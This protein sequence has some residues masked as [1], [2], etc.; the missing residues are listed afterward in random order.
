MGILP[1]LIGVFAL[2]GAIAFFRIKKINQ[3]LLNLEFKIDY[4]TKQIEGKNEKN[5]GKDKDVYISTAPP[6]VETWGP[7]ETAPPPKP[8]TI[9]TPSQPHISLESE[10]PKVIQKPPTDTTLI[11]LAWLKENWAG[12]LGV[13]I[14]VLGITFGTVYLS[15]FASPLLRFLILLGIG[16]GFFGASQ[17]IKTKQFVELSFWLRSASG[18]IVLFTMLASSF[19]EALHFYQSPQV[20]LA[21][22]VAGLIYNMAL[23]YSATKEHFAAFH[24]LICLLALMIVPKELPVLFS[25]LIVCLASIGISARR[26]W[27][28]NLTVSFI[29]YSIFHALWLREQPSISAI[30]PIGI[31]GT[32]LV[33]AGA[34]LVHYLKIYQNTTNQYLI[35]HII[36]WLFLGFDLALYNIGFSYLFIPLGI[37]TVACFS[38]S[39]YAKRN[40]IEW[41]FICD[42]LVGQVLAIITIL[43]LTRL[44]LNDQLIAWIAFV[45][46]VCF[47]TV[48]Y[49]TRQF[50][51]SKVGTGFTLCFFLAFVA[52]LFVKLH[53][54]SQTCLILA[55]ALLPLYIIR[56]LLVKRQ[57]NQC[58][59]FDTYEG[60]YPCIIDGLFFI[61]G[62]LTLVMG[63]DAF[64]WGY[65]L[66]IAVLI[67]MTLNKKLMANNYHRVFYL[68]FCVLGVVYSW[69]KVPMIEATSTALIYYGLPP[70]A[71]LLWLFK[72]KLFYIDE[73]RNIEDLWV[74]LVGFHIAIIGTMLSYAYSPFLP[75]ALYLLFGLI[76]FETGMVLYAGSQTIRA[77]FLSIACKNM[78]LLFLI[79]YVLIY[80]LLYIQS[81]ASLFTYLSFAHA[82]TIIA[83]ALSIYWYFSRPI[84]SDAYPELQGRLSVKMLAV[85][86]SVTFDIAFLLLICLLI[87]TFSAPLHPIGYGILGLLLSVPYLRKYFPARAMAY[88]VCLLMAVCVQVSVVSSKWASPL[89]DWYQNTHITG[90]ISMVLALGIASFLLKAPEKQENKILSIFYKEPILI[91]MLPTF[92]ALGLFLMWRF[93]KAY[94]TMLWVIEIAA[95]V[96]IGFYLRSKWLV[97]IALLFLAFCVARLLFYDLAQTALIIKAFVFIVIGLLMIFI[98]IIYKKYASRLS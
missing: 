82:L 32:S 35:S 59:P 94:L 42:S 87:S 70:V 73:Q 81:E 84:Q 41:L 11:A 40:N 3:K 67:A 78:T 8:L 43:T 50:T 96:A 92:I 45:E 79:G 34:L 69:C 95:V 9:T 98:H 38:M 23:A 44:N 80:L 88:A 24:V 29:A 76:F 39:L 86:E 30:A 61:L 37:A 57:S 56:N 53:P 33:G 4:L 51:L 31:V 58:P 72:E 17:L 12:F 93:D 14:L 90:P 54:P 21:L 28:I 89:S 15:Y 64:H 18:A 36:I 85:S 83:V 62:F 20:G 16:F 47:A 63:L 74:Y 22:L 1:L 68:L 52:L 26:P 55:G 77:S 7:K 75:G 91:G 19:I 48:A 71:L 5:I 25:G 6:V 46:S 10:P 27:D 66:F 60:S 49:W 2:L 65:S 13:S 97:H